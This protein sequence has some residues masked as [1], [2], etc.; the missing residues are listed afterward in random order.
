MVATDVPP[1]LMG[2]YHIP[3][4]SP[5]RDAANSTNAVGSVNAPTIDIDGAPRPTGTRYDI[6]ADELPGSIVL[7]FPR[8]N[9]LDT[10]SIPNGALGAGWGGDTSQSIYRVQSGQVQ[11][12]GS[13]R[14]WRTGSTPGANQE[15]F[16][17]ITKVGTGATRH[18]LLL[19]LRNAGTSNESYIRV[20]LSPGGTVKVHT[21]AP[22]HSPVLRATFSAPFVA[23]D[24]FGVRATSDGTVT[25]YRNGV[26]IGHTN[27]TRGTSPWPASLV[28][29][30]GRIAVIYSGNT[31]SN[32]AM[33][34]DFG[35]GTLP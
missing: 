3:T 29:S 4:S 9:V 24:T 28:G 10:F 26:A 35:G 33:F 8:T 17:R 27:V 6:G 19:K 31:T 32:D 11:V 21:K 22:K 16:L 20:T 18:G 30:S 13:G 15:A 2:D 25:V 34:D 14:I 23:G 1:T 12:R 7:A 5:A